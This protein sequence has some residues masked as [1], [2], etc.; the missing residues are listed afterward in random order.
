MAVTSLAVPSVASSVVPLVASLAVPS[1]ASLAVPLAASLANPSA[2]SLVGVTSSAAA[3]SDIEA[4]AFDTEAAAV[5][6]VCW[7]EEDVTRL[8]LCSPLLRPCPYFNY[9]FLHQSESSRGFGVL[10]STLSIVFL[11]FAISQILNVVN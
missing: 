10:G 4:A 6:W 7:K 3:T 5:V 11:C 2:T 9:Y 1:A 8:I